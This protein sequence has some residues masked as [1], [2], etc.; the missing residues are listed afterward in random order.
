[1][2]ISKLESKEVVKEKDKEPEQEG[3]EKEPDFKKTH[4]N[5]LYK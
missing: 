5:L 1:M 4:T 3:L 2:V